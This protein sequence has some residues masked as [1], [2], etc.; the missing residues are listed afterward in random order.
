MDTL[1]VP[2]VLEVPPQ[3]SPNEETPV[4]FADMVLTALLAR[5]AGVLNAEHH[6]PEPSVGWFIDP[7]DW[8][9]K[10]THVPVA[11]SPSR[12]AFRTVLAR[13]GHHYMG[14]QLYHGYALRFLR[15][16][17]RVLR[18]HFYMSNAGQSGF[19]IEIYSAR[20]AEQR[21][22]V[23][24]APGGRRAN[25]VDDRGA[26]LTSQVGRSGCVGPLAIGKVVWGGRTS[27]YGAGME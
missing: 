21:C 25:R 3:L 23:G 22:E 5:E 8:R 1:E 9:G 6:D 20:M 2:E 14:G 10:Q 26:L 16:R 18:C 19:W 12:G 15:Q 17:G 27:G 13:F 11:V 4:A 24:R 7:L